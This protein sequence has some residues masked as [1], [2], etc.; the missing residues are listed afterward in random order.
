MA[1]L[2]RGDWYDIART[3]NWTPLHAS[4]QDIF[5]D[6]MSDEFGLSC[7]Q[8]EAYD[9]PYKISYREYVKV[10]ESKDTDT[11]SVRSALARSN[12]YDQ[13][14]PGW[15][16]ILKLHFGNLCLPEYTAMVGEAKMARFGKAPGWRNMATL[17]CLDE[18]R[19][20]QMQLF[21]AHDFTQKSRQFDFS[22]KMMHANGWASIASRH[23]LD[24]LLQSR[25]A[26]T[27]AITLTFSIEQGFTNLQFMG[28]A[29]DAANAGDYSFSNMCASVQTDEARH[30]QIGAAA[31]KVLIANGKKEQVQRAVDVAFWREWR[32]FYTLSGPAVDY[33]TPLAHREKSFKEFVEE[34]IIQQFERSILD[35]GL[36]KP[37]YWDYFLETIDYFH[38]G[39]HLMIWYVRNTVFWDPAASVGPAERA[40]LE[41]KYPGWNEAWGPVWD[42]VT[43]NIRN[44]REDLTYPETLPALC[45]ICCLSPTGIAHRGH[46]TMRGHTLDYEGRRYIFCSPVCQ[47]IFEQDP[48]RYQDHKSIVD[49][50]VDGTIQPHNMDGVLEYFDMAPG[51]QGED[52]HAL[53]WA[54][55]ERDAD[56]EAA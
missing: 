30:A 18:I 53:A 24:D 2:D 8:W 1:L 12:Y 51:E 15:R 21:F 54:W 47:W 25:D 48:A 23:S 46:S 34:Y 28:L 29:A 17:G 16:S 37:W 26:A 7:D 27:M 36:D 6:P 20:C 11:Y 40:W 10:Q 19:H 14:D 4:E 32:L 9:E 3:T 45:N 44:G 56:A 41:E 5:P 31:M 55:P 49:R 13:A 42:V 33:L 43:E 35:L 22:H 50:Y 52:A 39:G 38:H